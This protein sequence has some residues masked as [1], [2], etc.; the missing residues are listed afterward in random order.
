MQTS[1]KFAVHRE[2]ILFL[3]GA[4]MLAGG[5]VMAAW[6]TY[7]L[8]QRGVVAT[9]TVL[10]E[11][12]SGKQMTRIDVR[13]VTAGGQ[14]V[15]ADTEHYFSAEVGR[16]IQVL[17]DPENPQRLQAANWDL[18]YQIAMIWFGGA[19]VFTAAGVVSALGF[20]TARLRQLLQGLRT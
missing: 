2:A 7:L 11:R 14:T 4:G 10:D 8:D 1:W 15:E 18:D 6:D 3:L 9:A 17:Y 20:T 5:G 19:L 13:F 12:P 16:E